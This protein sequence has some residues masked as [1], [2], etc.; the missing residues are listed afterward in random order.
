[1]KRILQNNLDKIIRT[2]LIVGLILAIA[3]GYYAYY[4]NQLKP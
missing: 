4:V 2:T 3:G 1:M